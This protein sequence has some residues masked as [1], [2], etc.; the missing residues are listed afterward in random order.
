MSKPQFGQ[1]GVSLNDGSTNLVYLYGISD[2]WSIIFEDSDKVQ[3]LLEA[4]TFQLSEIYSRFLQL[5]STLTLDNIQT[6]LNS[7]MSLVLIDEK[8]DALSGSKRVFTLPEPILDCD[9]I[10]NRPFLPTSTLSRGVH[11]DLSDDGKT[12]TLYSNLDLLKF[13]RR[14]VNGST[15]QFALWMTN[16]K[17]DEQIVYNYFG[18]FVKK[19]PEV[20]TDRYKDFISGL[21]YLYLSGPTIRDL[22]RGLNL[23]MGVPL[24]RQNEKV[25]LVDRL[26]G[27]QDYTVVTDNNSYIVP[28]GLQPDIVEGDT[29]KVGDPIASWVEVKDYKEED[30]WWMYLTIPPEMLPVSYDGNRTAYPGNDID[31]LMRN[32]LKNHSFLV[33]LKTTGVTS[34]NLF[35]ELQGIVK[36]VKPS[37]TFPIYIWE[38]PIE[39]E[40]IWLENFFAY[41]S[42]AHIC[43]NLTSPNPDV[44][45]RDIEDV[46]WRECP[47]FIRYNMPWKA[48]YFMTNHNIAESNIV[49]VDGPEV[50]TG[51][52]NA[53]IVSDRDQH[54]AACM[55]AVNPRSSCARSL[56]RSAVNYVNYID[57]PYSGMPVGINYTIQP[58]EIFP[59]GPDSPYNF[60]DAD[61]M[62]LYCTTEP[63]LRFK[64]TLTE[65]GAVE[66]ERDAPP[67]INI[68]NSYDNGGLFP[69]SQNYEISIYLAESQVD[70]F[71]NGITW[72]FNQFV[73]YWN[74]QVLFDDSEILNPTEMYQFLIIGSFEYFMVGQRAVFAMWR[75]NDSV[76][77]NGQIIDS[78]AN[79]GGSITVVGT[80]PAVQD[81]LIGVEGA[82]D[83]YYPS[84]DGTSYFSQSPTNPSITNSHYT[85][86]FFVKTT[87][88]GPD[89][90][91][92]FTIN[93][94]S[95]DS[96]NNNIRSAIR[97]Q[98]GYITISTDGNPANDIYSTAQINDGQPHLISLA[99]NRL[100]LVSTLLIDAVVD[101]V[102]D[103]D[104]TNRTV[105]STDRILLGA[106]FNGATIQRYAHDVVIGEYFIYKREETDEMIDTYNA[107]QTGKLDNTPYVWST[108]EE[109]YLPFVYPGNYPDYIHHVASLPALP[110][111][112]YFEDD[113]VILTDAPYNQYRLRD[114]AFEPLS[115]TYNHYGTS[116]AGYD[117]HYLE[118]DTNPNLWGS[119]DQTLGQ[120]AYDPNYR[121][122]HIKQSSGDYLPYTDHPGTYDVFVQNSTPSGA[123]IGDIWVNESVNT[124][125]K[126]WSGSAWVN[127]QSVTG[128][129]PM[130]QTGDFFPSAYLPLDP[131]QIMDAL[132]I[133]Y[134]T[135]DI[136]YIPRINA[137]YFYDEVDLAWR[138]YYHPSSI[139][140]AGGGGYVPPDPL[141]DMFAI[142]VNLSSQANRERFL[143]R[144]FGRM[145]LLGKNW[146]DEY[147]DYWFLA[148]NYAKDN[149]KVR[150]LNGFELYPEGY[151]V[152]IK[153]ENDIYGVYY[154]M[155]ADPVNQ[156][157]DPSWTGTQ[158]FPN[159]FPVENVEN[160]AFDTT[161]TAATRG[162]HVIDSELFFLRGKTVMDYTDPLNT[163][164]INFDRTGNTITLN[165]EKEHT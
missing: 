129:F 139:I 156:L 35:T 67:I 31:W 92:L 56:S 46:R 19:S 8:A 148:N 113:I 153:I 16:V 88:S 87:Y 66:G 135:W 33:K 138:L 70:V 117:F 116:H 119:F 105:V 62:P 51:F 107:M 25:L 1:D 106:Q 49:D 69:M 146:G 6:T 143:V 9:Y 24:A 157:Y 91:P 82:S 80:I 7:Q 47:E 126:R 109:Q 131:G 45:R 111:E 99:Y 154:K 85:V 73:A 32:Y 163:G 41:Y 60:W 23:V 132:S 158:W 52:A 104:S 151:I 124:N 125:V 134:S 15:N 127:F 78:T 64:L 63:E 101:P 133:S 121:V 94:S 136:A 89:I 142:Q 95:G 75:L 61:L 159:Y 42:N 65:T 20:S 90:I 58:T 164:P 50:I 72:N 122:L 165:A 34:L 83:I 114:G 28:Y 98:D 21:Y 3:A 128:V 77:A 12:L 161:L 10:C 144:N 81:T 93:K 26:S 36:T 22:I 97:M 152:C 115:T 14:S 59:P 53:A 150:A 123:T 108:V 55:L 2:F 39:E 43:S 71:Y 100:S 149:Y 68:K 140:E 38:V 27:S 5:T 155:S 137:L 48:H 120:L 17:V 110:H 76:F 44:F 103:G 147:Y 86:S 11:Y 141:P 145:Q 74:P 18:R 84:F 162:A 112:S 37:Y 79:Y 54:T 96:S 30:E 57:D 13:P 40:V 118:F 102:L 29:L 4:T 160:L 130:T